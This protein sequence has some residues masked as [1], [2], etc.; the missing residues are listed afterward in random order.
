MPPLLSECKR[1]RLHALA[2][3]LE[4]EIVAATLALVERIKIVPV[5]SECTDL[6]SIDEHDCFD[7]LCAVLKPE[8]EVDFAALKRHTDFSCC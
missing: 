5:D 6:F 1:K 4:D 3:E 8:N 2:L 7:G